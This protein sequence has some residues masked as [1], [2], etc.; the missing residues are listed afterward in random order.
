[1]RG[2][3]NVLLLWCA[4]SVL[5]SPFRG[6]SA[7]LSPGRWIHIHRQAPQANIER[8]FSDSG[9]RI[10]VGT[11]GGF[12]VF[13]GV[14]WH[15]YEY[16]AEVLVNH[17]PFCM[18]PEGR[19]YFIDGGDLVVWDEGI[20]SRYGSVEIGNP[21]EG[22]FAGDGTLYICSF[23]STKGGLFR[24][25][26]AH[27]VRVTGG[28]VRSAALD[29][30]GNLWVT[31]LEPD[32]EAMYL[33][34]LRDGDW[35]DLT[36]DVEFL[37]PVTTNELTV[38]AAP[39][40][41]IWVG[42]LGKYGI[43]RDGA[44]SFRDGGGAPVFLRF[45][46]TG[47]IWGYGYGKLYRLKGNGDWEE[48]FLIESAPINS[49]DFLTVLP[50]GSIWTFSGHDVYRFNGRWFEVV[51]SRFDLASDT[52]TCIAYDE[53]GSL[54]CGHGLREMAPDDRKNEGIS[55]RR[56]G[57]WINGRK[58]DDVEFQNVFQLKRMPDGEVMAYTDGGFKMMAGGS[59]EKLDSLFVGNQTDM[60]WDGDVMWITTTRGLIEYLDGPEFD[61]YFPLGG[62]L[63][64]PL[65]N[66]SITEDRVL[67]MQRNIGDI[68]TFDGSEWMTVVYDDGFTRDFAVAADGTIWSARTSHLSWWD[69]YARDWVD[70]IELDD[71][72]VIEIDPEGRIWASGYGNTGYYEDGKWHEIPELSDYACDVIAFSPDGR[73]A[74]NVFD[75]DRARFYGLYEFVPSTVV[76]KGKGAPEE[77]IVTASHPNPFNASTTI[78]FRLEAAEF[79]RIDVYSSN[80]QHV[81]RLADRVFP[82]GRNG[83]IWDG[84][85]GTGEVLATGVYFYRVEAG[86]RTGIGKM[87]F[88]K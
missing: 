82:P 80:G 8:I 85:S 7:E 79:V 41:A 69:S 56:D 57:E 2:I 54:V 87:L 84:T 36:G 18:D 9:G 6:A 14:R 26:G 73:I 28:R 67:Y 86:G 21:V 1:M 59:W 33:K 78:T 62:D 47:G 16:D 52:V 23:N 75:R 42:N 51:E 61:F 88:L 27:L 55:V 71:G 68:V 70:V 13:D 76:E 50:D 74:V 38:Q 66:L 25:D 3:R 48:M 29:A 63:V 77:Y 37:Y 72:R 15:M 5:V 24:F 32:S 17:T 10:V 53:D 65:N 45:D 60:V 35:V 20:V 22:V 19:L 12:H 46:E 43:F 64:Y 11:G 81:A 49:S 58:F 40:G 30:S 39:D 83:V 4:A 44:W 31:G 34:T